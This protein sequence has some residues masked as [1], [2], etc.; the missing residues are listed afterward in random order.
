ML[1]TSRVRVRLTVPAALFALLS[2]PLT[3]HA[4]PPAA[5]HAGV[6]GGSD[7][8][9]A[10][11]A[12]VQALQTRLQREAAAL[13]ANT[14]LTNAQKQA[15]YAALVQA[16]NQSVL[17]ILT[18]TQRAEELKRRQINAQFQKDVAALRADTKLT[19][20]QK[21]Q[22]YLALVQKAD[23]STLQT[24][25]ASQKAQV[26]QQRH[27]QATAMQIAQELHQSQT[28]AQ[29]KKIHDISNAFGA[30]MRAVIADKGLSNQAKT[31]K[32]KALT[33]QE[34]TQVSAL[35]TPAQ[36]V[37]FQQWQRLVSASQPR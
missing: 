7:L 32:I 34:E 22:R 13:G 17:G 30:Q 12:Q 21:K 8:S 15:K 1:L 4:Q 26:L 6:P 29:A 19:D 23:A 9:P 33:Q 35:L 31:A 11:R 28:P 14:K 25:S 3:T 36:R 2:L 24:L 27:T 16:A 5:S 37:K 10:Q 20:A 18:P